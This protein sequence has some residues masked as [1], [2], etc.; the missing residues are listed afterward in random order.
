DKLVTGVQT[1]ALPISRCRS[2]LELDARAPILTR[3]HAYETPLQSYSGDIDLDFFR[4]GLL[5]LRQMHPEQAV[6]ELG[7]HLVGI[8]IFRESKA[9]HKGA[10]AAFNAVIFLFLLFLL[11]LADRKSV[12]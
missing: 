5:A 12:V 3:T 9:A 10:V 7:L 11:E 8:S 2:P 1:C 6:L 4:F